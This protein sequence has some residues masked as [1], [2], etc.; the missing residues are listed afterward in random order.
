M[1]DHS[2]TLTLKGTVTEFQWTNPHAYLD[3][4][5]GYEADAQHFTIE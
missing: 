4:R 3:G 2:R 5:A 1:F